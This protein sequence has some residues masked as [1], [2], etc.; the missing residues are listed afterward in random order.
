MY[1][2]FDTRF[3]ATNF[4]PTRAGRAVTPSVW[5]AKFDAELPLVLEDFGTVSNDFRIMTRVG[6]C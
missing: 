4:C 3:Y 1:R 5:I 2:T 6:T